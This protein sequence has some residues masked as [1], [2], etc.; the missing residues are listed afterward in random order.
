LTLSLNRPR[1]TL[2]LSTLRWRNPC[3]SRAA[4]RTRLAVARNNLGSSLKDLGRVAEAREAYQAAADLD[5]R[6]VEAHLNLGICLLDAGEVSAAQR[7]FDLALEQRPESALAFLGLGHAHDLLG[8]RAQA[9]ANY[10][11]ASALDGELAEARFNYSLQL[12]AL[13]EFE[14]G[15]KEYEWRWRLDTRTTLRPAAAHWEGESLSGKTILLYAEQGFGDALQFVRY[16]PLVA[17]SA[18][19][20][21]LRCHPE[22]VE[23][24]SGIPEVHAVAASDA[25]L[26]P[27]DVC[28]PLMSLPRLFKTTPETIP[29]GVPYLRPPP[30]HAREWRVRIPDDDRLHIGIAWASNPGTRLGKQKSLRLET[31]AAI[32][33]GR[34]VVLHSLQKGPAAKEAAG[35]AGRLQ[36][37]EHDEELKSFADTAGLI[38]RLDLVITVDTAVAHLAGALAKPV[39]TLVAYPPVW[40]WAH[41]G[42]TSLWYPTMRL[43]RQPE[44]GRWDRVVEQLAEAVRRLVRDRISGMPRA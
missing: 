38:A 39:W 42:D 11:S 23:L 22:L 40:R 8:Q 35:A 15:W 31:L 30:G 13:G 25:G 3:A 5:P 41:E 37:V 34:D 4:R 14:S 44:P 36:L 33:V 2:R 9:I 28:A 10:R 27:F 20:V 17:R 32:P 19:R 16:A 21:L 24:F 12:L 26:P 43:F 1:I 18:D 7:H 29:V 6:L